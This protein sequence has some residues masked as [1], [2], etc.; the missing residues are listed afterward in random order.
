LIL[1]WVFAYKGIT[2]KLNFIEYNQR[3]FMR[4]ID[5]LFAKY[6][7]ENIDCEIVLH[8]CDNPEFYNNKINLSTH[9][10]LV[11]FQQIDFQFAHELTHA[12][13]FA[14]G[15][16]EIKRYN[17]NEPCELEARKNARYVMHDLLG[18]K[19]YGIAV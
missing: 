4:I 8:D 13:Q 18:Y 9:K 3:D 19:D 14:K 17:D 12:I 15:E 5:C 6:G 2:S 16:I 10:S 1:Y 11:Y 7:V